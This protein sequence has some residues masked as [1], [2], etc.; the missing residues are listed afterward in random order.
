[1]SMK[2]ELVFVLHVKEYE[3]RILRGRGWVPIS[4]IPY[5]RTFVIRTLN[6]RTFVLLVPRT[7]HTQSRIVRV[8]ESRVIRGTRFHESN[9]KP[10]FLG[11][12]GFN[13][14]NVKMDEKVRLPKKNI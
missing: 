14:P 7:T 9:L 3:V 11:Q 4:D 13:R 12:F 10:Y 1:M 8:S 2:Y 6:T 5:I